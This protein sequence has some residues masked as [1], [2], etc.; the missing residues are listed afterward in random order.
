MKS[1]RKASSGVPYVLSRWSKGADVDVLPPDRAAS[2]ASA[3]SSPGSMSSG[4]ITSSGAGTGGVGFDRQLTGFDLAAER[5]DLD[6]L[7]I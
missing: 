6:R 1:R 5:R 3:A 2:S 4:A 7:G